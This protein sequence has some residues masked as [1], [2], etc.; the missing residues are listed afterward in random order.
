MI[1]EVGKKLCQ[2]MD[3]KSV[4]MSDFFGI[5]MPSFSKKMISMGLTEF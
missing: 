4:K 2:K 1:Q 5:K 3:Q